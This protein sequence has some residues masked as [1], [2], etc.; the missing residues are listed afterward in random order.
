MER[1]GNERFELQ[2]VNMLQYQHGPKDCNTKILLYL[3]ND[4]HCEFAHGGPCN[5]CQKY[6]FHK[7]TKIV[8]RTLDTCW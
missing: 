1:I 5:M 2:A 6:T 3:G 8:H 4:S 7:K